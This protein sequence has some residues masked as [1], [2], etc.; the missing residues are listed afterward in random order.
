MIFI[1]AACESGSEIAEDAF[2]IE[3]KTHNLPMSQETLTLKAVGGKEP[4][5]W[6]ISD[7]T[8]GTLTGVTNA[9]HVTY[10][11]NAKNGTQTVEVTDKNTW[12][13]RSLIHQ[14]ATVDALTITPTSATLNSDGDKQVFT[15]SGGTPPYSWSVG[16]AARGS[17]TVDGWSQAVYTRSASGNN[18]VIVSDS[19]GHSAIAE[20][21][22]PGVAAL[23]IS[24]T[25]VTV[26]INETVVFTASGGVSPYTWSMQSAPSGA[27]APVPNSGN[28]TAYTAGGTTNTTDV[29]RLTDGNGTVALGTVKVR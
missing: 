14:V 26:D 19:Q 23:A 5:T 27:G 12:T 22:Q 6:R 2:R 9:R 18:T 15:G 25:S 7:D 17:V 29:V 10:T 21:S 24:P 20:I 11:R 8:L 4:F 1:I 28:Q 3:P 13:A 16:T